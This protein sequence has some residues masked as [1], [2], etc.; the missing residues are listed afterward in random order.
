MLGV[1]DRLIFMLRS[2]AA[3]E[4]R[5]DTRPNSDKSNCVSIVWL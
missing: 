1:R 5:S 2:R 4:G 3:P